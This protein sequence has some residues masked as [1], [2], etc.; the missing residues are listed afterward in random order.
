MNQG[1]GLRTVRVLTSCVIFVLALVSAAHTAHALVVNAED[2]VP[3]EILHVPMTD[4]VAFQPISIY[5]LVTDDVQ[6]AEVTLYYRTTDAEDYAR[7]AMPP[8]VSCIDAYNATILGSEVTTATIAYYV[9]ASDGHNVVLDGSASNPHLIRINAAPLPV[10]VH[11]PTDIAP[12][13]MT[14]A[15]TENLDADF[16]N[17]TIHVST[18]PGARGAAIHAITL[19]STTSYRVT[20]LSPATAYHFTVRVYDAGGLHADSP[21]ISGTTATLP[22][23][24]PPWLYAIA[25]IAVIGALAVAGILA[26]TR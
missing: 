11:V 24:Q 14:V 8:C 18:I 12:D 19:Q 21:P 2:A 10:V 23:P 16:A 3:P 4:S 20:G 6:V 5:V 1:H 26:K 13:A 25:G 15:W 7:I 22:D 9:N 17:Y